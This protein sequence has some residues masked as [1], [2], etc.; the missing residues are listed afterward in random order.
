MKK[1]FYLIIVLFIGINNTT[2]QW[3]TIGLNNGILGNT[4]GTNTN[5]PIRIFTFGTHRATWTTNN[6]LSSWN[7]NM[8]DGLRIHNP[9]LGGSG[10]N[11]DLFTSS[12]LGQNETHI[13]WGASGQ[14]SGQA[15]RFEQRANLC[16]ALLCFSL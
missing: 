13:V 8:G 3:N 12:N 5:H 6:S 9:L 2:A 10:G 1:I 11:L 15:L 4:F 14:I 16:T 7:N